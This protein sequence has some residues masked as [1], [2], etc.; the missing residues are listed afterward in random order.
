MNKKE[1]R[2]ILFTLV[3]EYEFNREKDALEI[4]EDARTEREF[5]NYRYI[6]KGLSDIVSKRGVLLISSKNIPM[7]GR[8]PESLR[9]PELFCSLPHMI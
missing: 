6:K 9:S 2:E 7:D 5:E 8:Y 3:Y 4:Y 1:A